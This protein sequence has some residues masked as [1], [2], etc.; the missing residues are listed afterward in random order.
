M[1]NGNEAACI[2]GVFLCL[3]VEVFWHRGHDIIKPPV[4]TGGEWKTE[5][6]FVIFIVA[7]V[8]FP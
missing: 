1:I 5:G 2:A 6:R 4:Y 8:R 3:N 7:I